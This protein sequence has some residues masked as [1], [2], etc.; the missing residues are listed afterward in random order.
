MK[1]IKKRNPEYIEVN[2]LSGPGW[3]LPNYWDR[4]F[5]PR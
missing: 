4:D 3:A 5:L 1:K 2:G